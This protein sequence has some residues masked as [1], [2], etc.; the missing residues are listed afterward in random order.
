MQHPACRI[1]PA[2]GVPD[3]VRTEIIKAF[4]SLNDGYAGSEA[5]TDELK[6]SVRTRLAKHEILRLVE[7]VTSP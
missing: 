6:A 5:L 4:V 2:I 7:F 1:V 3:P